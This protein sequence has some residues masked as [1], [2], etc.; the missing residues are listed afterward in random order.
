MIVSEQTTP[1][2]LL[3]VSQTGS[4]APKPKLLF[5]IE[6]DLT[7]CSEITIEI[8]FKIWE[9]HVQKMYLTYK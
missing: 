6:V 9:K 2:H 8:M 7:R 3:L 5:E 1:P 4:P